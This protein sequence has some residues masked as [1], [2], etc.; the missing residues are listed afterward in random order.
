MTRI[1]T[2]HVADMET[3]L[4]DCASCGAQIG[5]LLW[6]DGRAF[7]QECPG[8]GAV[9]KAQRVDGGVETGVEVLHWQLQE[10]KEGAETVLHG[11]AWCPRCHQRIATGAGVCDVCAGELARIEADNVAS[12]AYNTQDEDDTLTDE[13]VLRAMFGDEE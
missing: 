3:S 4:A 12:G 2:E 1:V 13:D 9:I 8:C 6:H 7:I 10:L 5:V 11:K